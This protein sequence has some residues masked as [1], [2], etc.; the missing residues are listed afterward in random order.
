[1]K[2]SERFPAFYAF[3]NKNKRDGKVNLIPDKKKT[4]T[5]QVSGG[6]EEIHEIRHRK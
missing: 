6:T 1:M 4:P 3:S 2:H 5:L